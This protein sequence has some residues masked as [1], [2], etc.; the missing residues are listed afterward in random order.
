MK[1]SIASSARWLRHALRS[2]TLSA[3][4]AGLIASSVSAQTAAPKGP[5]ITR[6]S[7][8]P[9]NVA[10]MLMLQR[11][12]GLAGTGEGVCCPAPSVA[13]GNGRHAG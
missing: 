5:P 3:A 13:G 8:V 4:A 6:P 2:L 10:Q 11:L 12:R 1:T 7:A 9:A